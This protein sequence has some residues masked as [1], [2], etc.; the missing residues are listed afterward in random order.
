MIYT[1]TD[2]ENSSHIK[3]MIS[4]CK[5]DSQ[6][7]GSKLRLAHY[8]LGRELT[9]AFELKLQSPIII[10]FL[11]AGIPFSLG[12][13]DILDCPILFY[14]DK[15]A[16]CF[17]QQQAKQLRN[18]FLVLIDSV[19][20]TG[21]GI[22]KVLENLERTPKN[23]LI[24]TNV[25]CDKAIKKLSAYE[26]FT[27]RISQNSFIGTNIKVQNENKGPDTGDRL[28]KTGLY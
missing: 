16:S 12:V 2:I 4:I 15:N 10:C 21:K 20:N 11:R 14:D 1:L 9:K 19:I 18:K 7:T 26:I 6:V 13:A 22:L 23:T 27:V 24:M 3:E 5:S 25:L 28:F 8:S 17:F